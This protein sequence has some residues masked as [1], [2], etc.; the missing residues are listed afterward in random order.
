MKKIL[1]VDD[2]PGVVIVSAFDMVLGTIPFK[3]Q[4]LNQLAAYWFQVSR[5]VAPSSRSRRY[6]PP[7]GAAARL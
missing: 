2:T 6:R 7:V 4:I 1:Y 3:G 5:A